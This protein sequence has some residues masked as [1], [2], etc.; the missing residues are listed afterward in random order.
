MSHRLPARSTFSLLGRRLSEAATCELLLLVN[1]PGWV[2]VLP[3]YLLSYVADSPSLP[4]RP[5]GDIVRRIRGAMYR[6]FGLRVLTTKPFGN[7][8]F[9]S[10]LD[11]IWLI[12]AEFLKGET[13]G[14]ISSPGG[15]F[16]DIGAHHGL[17]SAR[18]ASKLPR[19]SRIIAIEAH[20]INYSVL[21]RNIELNQLTNISAFNF[22]V[23]NFNGTAHMQA[24]EGAS[25]RYKLSEENSINSPLVIQCYRLQEVFAKFGIDRVD[26]I[27]LDIEGLELKVVQDCLPALGSR[28]REF[29]IEVHCPGD[30][31]PMRNIL[32]SNGFAVHLERSGILSPAYRLVAE[33]TSPVMKPVEAS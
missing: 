6:S 27:K 31:A 18:M 7:L 23:A 32:I 29:D 19:S 20:P 9:C 14:H 33:K 11:G 1:F 16:I 10:D 22:A 4:I 24:P 25:A 13:P 21:R 17:V 28:I 15:V 8:R 26:L 12:A 5:I 3:L 2:L 30:V